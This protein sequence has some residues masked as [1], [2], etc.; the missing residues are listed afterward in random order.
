[1]GFMEAISPTQNIY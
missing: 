1:M